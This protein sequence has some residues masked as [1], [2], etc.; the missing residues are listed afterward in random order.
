ME[1]ETVFEF[2][3]KQQEKK[4][5]ESHYLSLGEI[6]HLQYKEHEINISD[7]VDKLKNGKQ[8][9]IPLIKIIK[10]RAAYKQY[11]LNRETKN[12]EAKISKKPDLPDIQFPDIVL[13]TL[14]D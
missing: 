11:L 1:Q 5:T 9:K 2:V 3:R 6:V 8:L 10:Q 14:P 4:H 13:P 7:L 12:E